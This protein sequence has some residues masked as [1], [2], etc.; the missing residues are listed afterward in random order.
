M[1]VPVLGN[2]HDFKTKNLLGQDL[3]IVDVTTLGWHFTRAV[4]LIRLIVLG[5]GSRVRFPESAGTLQGGCR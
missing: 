4:S 5:H 3:G 2:I 1:S